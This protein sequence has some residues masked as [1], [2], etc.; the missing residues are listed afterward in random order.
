MASCNYILL[1]LTFRDK[2]MY[3]EARCLGVHGY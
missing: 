3:T 1:N 2:A